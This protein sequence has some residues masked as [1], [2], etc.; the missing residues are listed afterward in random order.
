MSLLT[1]DTAKENMF[2]NVA[3]LFQDSNLQKVGDSSGGCRGWAKRVLKEAREVRFLIEKYAAGQ[4]PQAHSVT[5]LT[6]IEVTLSYSR[7]GLK[8]I[9]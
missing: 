7:N 4:V 3:Q 1:M 6:S 5:S 9:H 8:I 2:Q